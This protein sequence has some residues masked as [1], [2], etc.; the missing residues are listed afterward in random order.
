VLGE[1]ADDHER[2]LYRLRVRSQR[3]AGPRHVAPAE[4]IAEPPRVAALFS[5]E[6]PVQ[7]RLGRLLEDVHPHNI[8]DVPPDDPL[9][10]HPPLPL[11]DRVHL[12]IPVIPSDDGD[13][14]R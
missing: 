10:R 4:G 7:V 13:A 9:C 1:V 3:R 12:L 14:I 6:A 5:V 8:G 11:V 2:R